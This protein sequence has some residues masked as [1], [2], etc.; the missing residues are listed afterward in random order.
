M[1]IQ[2][3]EIINVNGKL[4]IYKIEVKDDKSLHGCAGC[5]LYYLCKY[6]SFKDKAELIGICNSY[7][8]FKKC[9]D[10]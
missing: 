7:L 10:I 4:Y 3:N 8:R 9:T 6:I 5:E 1:I 2:K